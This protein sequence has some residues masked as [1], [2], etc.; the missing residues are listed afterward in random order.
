MFERAKAETSQAKKQQLVRMEV[1]ERLQAGKLYLTHLLME[2]EPWKM[3]ALYAIDGRRLEGSRTEPG[4]RPIPLPDVRLLAMTTDAHK[5][6]RIRYKQRA[7]RRIAGTLDKIEEVVEYVDCG[8]D[9]TL[10]HQVARDILRLN[11]WPI[12][13]NASMG[14]RKGW[15]IEVP[16]LLAEVERP[17][18]LEEVRD[19]YAHLRGRIEKQPTNPPKKAVAA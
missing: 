12:V 7:M 16:W 6:S 18:C 15:V 19:I 1:L 11:G 13:N 3:F 10:Q 4:D 9:A 17:D 5:H 14:N 2:A 8:H